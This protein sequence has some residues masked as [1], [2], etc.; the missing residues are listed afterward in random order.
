MLIDAVCPVF[1]L[2]QVPFH[3]MFTLCAKYHCVLPW[4]FKQA[5]ASLWLEKQSSLSLR[6]R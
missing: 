6:W 1:L 5:T 3:A 2:S 4:F